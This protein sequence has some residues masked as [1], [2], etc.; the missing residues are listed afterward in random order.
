MVKLLFLISLLFVFSVSGV[1]QTTKEI[2][3]GPVVKHYDNG[4]KKYEGQFRNNT[5]Y[6]MFRYYFNTGQLKAT[7]DYS[8]DGVYA[9][10][11]TYYKNGKKMAQ[12]RYLN[13]QKDGKWF[14]YLNE[15]DNP[16]VSMESY[17]NGIL[18][19]ESITYYPD[20]GNPAEIV[21]YKNG[22]KHGKLLKY[23]PDS[24]LMTE[25]YYHEGQ[26]HG[27]FRHYHPDGKLYIKGEYYY[28]VQAGNWEYFNENGQRI[29]EEEFM[30]QDNVEEIDQ[31]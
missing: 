1:S 11:I 27:K 29:P 31:P 23:F 10:S 5:P 7:M 26:P 13:R 18:E 8:D 22:N 30:K 12:G 20:G 21:E 25:S 17:V 2:K 19:G 3:D 9:E 14:Y 15:K 6:G 4:K 16:L 24:V 28:G